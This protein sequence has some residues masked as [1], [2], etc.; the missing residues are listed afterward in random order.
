VAAAAG[1][2]GGSPRVGWKKQKG[3]TSLWCP[4]ASTGLAPPA[5]TAPCRNQ[6]GELPEGI[7]IGVPPC[8][9]GKRAQFPI[10]C[11]NRLTFFV[12]PVTDL[13]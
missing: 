13:S 6:T 8:F 1:A 3:T 9:Q 12:A 5:F 11:R 7:A 4:S 10:A 2:A